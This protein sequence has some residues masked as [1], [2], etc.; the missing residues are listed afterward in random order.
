MFKHNLIIAFRNI[1]RSKSQFFIHLIGLSSGLACTILIY[2]WVKDEFNV[3]R[4]PGKD[5][6]LYSV[7]HNF[8]LPDGIQTLNLTP[9]PLAKALVE[10]MPEVEHAVAVNT[11]IDHFKG[12]GVIVNE[13]KQVKAQGLFATTD[14]FDV[15]PYRLLEGNKDEVL[16]D[17]K[18]V[19]IST[20]LAKR[21]FNT[22]QDVVGKT[23]EWNHK[24]FAGLFQVSGVFEGPSSNFTDQFDILFNYEILLEKD[25]YAKEWNGTYAETYIRLKEGTNVNDFNKKIHDFLQSKYPSGEQRKLFVQRYSKRYLYGRY[26]NGVQVGGRIE[27]IKLFSVIGLFIVVIACINFMNLFT[28]QASTKTKEIGVKKAIGIDRKSLVFQF[29]ANSMLTVFLSF[30][31]ACILVILLLPEFNEITNKHLYLALTFADIL[32]AIGIVIFTGIAAGLYPA[33]YL[34]SFSPAEVLKREMFPLENFWSGGGW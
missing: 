31:I 13:N 27:L 11:F 30:I 29:L 24:F 28:A 25:I 23:L 34:S 4:F 17:K 26:E 32:F 20:G 21:L 16:L 19:V 12:P 1:W 22:T 5:S 33:F 15:F 9:S 18:H 7:M 6:Q 8:H 14:Y 2:L 3:D 10:E